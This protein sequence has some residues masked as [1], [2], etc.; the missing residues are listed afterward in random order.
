MRSLMP[1]LLP[2]P[3]R[4]TGQ[5]LDWSIW[6]R[7]PLQGKV[8]LDTLEH[9]ETLIQIYRKRYGW[10]M[11]AYQCPRCRKYHLTSAEK[12]RKT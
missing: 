3:S 11:K 4:L 2:H 5:Q 7:C 6:G 12:K 9:A 8:R 10:K 1:T